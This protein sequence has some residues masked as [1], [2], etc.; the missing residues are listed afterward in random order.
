MKIHNIHSETEPD[1][2]YIV[3]EFEDGS[4]RCSCPRFVFNDK[5]PCKH[6]IQILSDETDRTKNK[7]MVQS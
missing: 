1:K 6:I 2:T 5:T 3:R 7:G 4:M